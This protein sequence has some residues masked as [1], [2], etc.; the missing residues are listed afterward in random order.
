MRTAQKTI[1]WRVDP[2]RHHLWA[3]KSTE[4]GKG[5][6]PNPGGDQKPGADTSTDNTEDDDPSDEDGEDDDDEE[7]SDD[8]D[9]KVIKLTQKQLNDKLAKERRDAQSKIQKKADEDR[10]K[11]EEKAL[12]DNKEHAQLAE[13][14]KG[15]RDALTP[16]GDRLSE[17]AT[18]IIDRELE[19]W[20]ESARTLVP[21]DGDI[22]TRFE[23]YERAK[24]FAA[25]L[26]EAKKGKKSPG[27]GE[28]E[29]KG[30][31]RGNP[32]PR[33]PAANTDDDKE[34]AVAQWQKMRQF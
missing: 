13:R 19:S 12:E 31:N 15:E 2:R 14:Y 3:A 30:G 16:K 10:R 29:D 5:G 7:G 28:Q 25:E 9:K 23:A 24:P 18:G 26:I 22:I 8:P 33:K 20:P 32:P 34:A 27:E 11:T 4:P 17:I 21:A 6:K 1:T